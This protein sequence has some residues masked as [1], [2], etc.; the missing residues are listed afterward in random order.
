MPGRARR[1]SQLPAEI[2]VLV[3]VEFIRNPNP[4]SSSWPRTIARNNRRYHRCGADRKALRA[5]WSKKNDPNCG[6]KALRAL[7]PEPG[8]TVAGDIALRFVSTTTGYPVRSGKGECLCGGRL[9]VQKTRRKTVLS[10]MG[11]LSPT[12]RYI[13]ARSVSVPLVPTRCCAGC[14]VAA[15]L[16]MMFWSLLGRP[17]FS[18]IARTEEVRTELA[19]RNVRLCASEVAYLG[20]KFITY[21]AVGHRQ[22]T[23]RIRQAMKLAG[24]YILHLDATHEGDAPALMTGIDSLE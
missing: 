7:D 15:M 2:A 10:M 17:C 20:R 23:P 3:L 18:G 4:A 8:D 9:V 24:G 11:R 14:R 13:N 5:A 19:V 6:A 16:P 22:A 21:L 12:R 1:Q